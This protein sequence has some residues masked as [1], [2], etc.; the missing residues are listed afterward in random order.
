MKRTV[1]MAA[2]MRAGPAAPRWAGMLF[3]LLVALP[4]AAESPGAAAV[5]PPGG[6]RAQAASDA[7]TATRA[8]ER[9]PD[10]AEPVR[11][12]PQEVPSVPL[13]EAARR[14]AAGGWLLMMRHAQ[15]EPGVGDPPSFRIGDCRTQRNLSDAGRQ[16]AARVGEAFRAAGV[17]IRSVR[18][19]Q[20]CRCKD[21]AEAAF[22]RHEEWP[23]LNSF[24]DARDHE[25][26]QNR[27]IGEFAATLHPPANVMLV[28]HQV[29]VA[30]ATGVYP[31]PAEIVAARWS[32]GRLAPMFRFR[33][34][35]GS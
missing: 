18:S 5:R 3:V 32:E 8:V 20:W 28:T 15:T 21:T 24:F 7:G 14:L 2:V 4:A 26:R 12:A 16:Q 6:A 9:A 30:S 22:G 29:N 31:A 11:S 33:A 17:R 23:A 13:R 19:S 1:A 27:E 34:D 35:G 25:A 10:A